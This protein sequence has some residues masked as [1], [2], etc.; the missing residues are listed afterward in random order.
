V[1]ESLPPLPLRLGE[2][3]VDKQ[4][5]KHGVTDCKHGVTDSTHCLLNISSSK[6]IDHRTRDHGH[7]VR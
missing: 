1:H 4:P 3:S 7:I 6:M 2:K 5:C